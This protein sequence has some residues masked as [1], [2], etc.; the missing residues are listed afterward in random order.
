MPRK[1][2]ASVVGW[3]SAL[4]ALIHARNVRP[5]AK[6]LRATRGE[7][8]AVHFT[9]AELLDPQF[10]AFNVT[11]AVKNKV[12]KPV[13]KNTASKNLQIAVEFANEIASGKPRKKALYLVAKKNK[14]SEELVRQ[15]WRPLARKLPEVF[16][17]IRPRKQN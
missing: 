17:H 14:I 9:I 12:G 11:L 3:S 10:K 1:A 5:I 4:N 13:G 7:F 8:E 2:K 6:L 16:G 15:C